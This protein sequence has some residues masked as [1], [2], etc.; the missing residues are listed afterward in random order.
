MTKIKTDGG[1]FRRQQYFLFLVVLKIYFKRMITEACD[2]MFKLS[3]E[4][5]VYLN[6][7]LDDSKKYLSNAFNSNKLSQPN[8]PLIYLHGKLQKA[9]QSCINCNF[10]ED[11]NPLAILKLEIFSFLVLKYFKKE[12]VFSLK[13]IN[14]DV[15]VLLA[16]NLNL[17][18][19]YKVIF[20]L[21]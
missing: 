4:N 21:L 20:I 10:N 13:I 11:N 16:I 9:V 2:Y 18:R 12:S 1:V 19:V 6:Q 8:E 7:V 3:D 15:I 14:F 17:E 5:I